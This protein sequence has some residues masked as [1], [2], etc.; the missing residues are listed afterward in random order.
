MANYYPEWLGELYTGIKEFITLT[1][2]NGDYLFK[3]LL[4][5]KA[6]GVCLIKEP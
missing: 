5:S 2:A 6:G 1:L 4:A 3:K